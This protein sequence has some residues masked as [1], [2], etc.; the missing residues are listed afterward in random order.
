MMQMASERDPVRGVTGYINML[1][2]I[3]IEVLTSGGHSEAIL[4]GGVFQNTPMVYRLM[5]AADKADIKLHLPSRI[6]VND[7]GIA[8]GQI[9]S[10]LALQ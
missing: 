10:T 9:A 2:D 5:S 1:V 3:I 6:P 4:C 8:L 7:G